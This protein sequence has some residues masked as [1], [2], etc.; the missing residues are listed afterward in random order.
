YGTVLSVDD[1]QKAF[2]IVNPKSKLFTLP[3]GFQWTSPDVQYDSTRYFPVVD[4]LYAF[5][6]SVPA[7][8]AKA[9][10]FLFHGID[11][12]NPSL[13]SQGDGAVAYMIS[14]VG[15]TGFV[16][17]TVIS[18]LQLIQP[19]NADPSLNSGFAY[20][21]GYSL[22]Y[23]P[24]L[25]D[26][27]RKKIFQIVRSQDL[28]KFIAFIRAVTSFKSA[29]D[30]AVNKDAINKEIL[31]PLYGIDLTHNPL[32]QSDRDGFSNPNNNPLYNK[33]GS[34]K[35]L[36][37]EMQTFDRIIDFRNV[38]FSK[39]FDQNRDAIIS[40]ILTP[41]WGIKLT[42]GKISANDVK[43]FTNN[44]GPKWNPLFNASHVLESAAD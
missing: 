44:T 8:L 22:T 39:Q 33:D 3:D 6:N 41:I 18:A 16:A 42:G 31:G 30:G 10:E 17:G 5:H 38:L 27:N 4:A 26:E 35:D 19:F 11:I 9:S 36:Q 24:G 15:T 1:Q 29:W 14:V 25:T 2:H 37:Q 13:I 23:G 21:E 43:A 28:T 40:Q 7:S 32:Q 20:V 12:S 34:L